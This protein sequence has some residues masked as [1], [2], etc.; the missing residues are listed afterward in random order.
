MPIVLASMKSFLMLAFGASLYSG[1]AV[2]QFDEG[3]AAMLQDIARANIAGIEAGKLASSKTENPGVMEFA[4]MMVKDHAKGLGEVRKVAAE[5]KVT[6]PRTPGAKRQTAMLRFRVLRGERSDRQ[7][8]KQAGVGDHEATEKL[9]QRTQAEAKDADV[10]ALAQKMLTVV[11]AHLA[12]ARAL[13][14]AQQ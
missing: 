8:I 1:G 2:A 3:D 7:Y 4:Q 5:K 13:A 12:H 11:Q 14:A 10:K 6:L 9:L